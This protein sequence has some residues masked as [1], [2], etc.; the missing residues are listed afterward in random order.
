MEVV[1]HDRKLIIPERHKRWTGVDNYRIL[2]N[3][4]RAYEAFP[5]KSFVARTPLIPGVNDDEEH[6]RAVLAFIKPSKNVVDY[7]LLPYMRFGESM[8]GFLGRVHEIQDYDP[9]TPALLV[10]L[11]A[12]ID[13]AFGRSG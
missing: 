7:E 8:Y 11:R 2:E 1:L 6:V 5:D 3:I 9:P 10:R 4:R 12:I 13:E